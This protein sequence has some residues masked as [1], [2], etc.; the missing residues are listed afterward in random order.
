LPKEIKA[1]DAPGDQDWS[2]AATSLTDREVMELILF[3]TPDEIKAALPRMTEA[4]RK[5]ANQ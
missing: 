3:G 4:Q 1:I 5:L 2:S